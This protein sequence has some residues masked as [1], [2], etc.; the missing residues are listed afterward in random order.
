VASG[1][2]WRRQTDHEVRLVSYDQILLDLLRDHPD[3][4][5]AFEYLTAYYL[6]RNMRAE[7]AA[8]L[9]RVRD[10][11]YDHLPRHYAEALV[12]HTNQIRQPIDLQGWSIDPAMTDQLRE[13][14]A[15]WR[16]LAGNRQAAMAALAPRFGDTYTFYSIFNLSGVK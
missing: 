16:S 2:R 8:N 12:V 6:L 1:R 9:Y 11:G 5:M 7:L 15:T 13:I 10:L 14:T 3:N 4:R